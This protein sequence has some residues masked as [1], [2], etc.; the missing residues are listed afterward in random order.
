VTVR[1]G[2]PSRCCKGI[3]KTPITGSISVGRNPFTGKLSFLISG[4][5][6]DYFMIIIGFYK[7]IVDRPNIR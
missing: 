7:G 6:N 2:D 5:S 3:H 4:K 1:V